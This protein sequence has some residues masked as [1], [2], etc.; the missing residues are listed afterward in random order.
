MSQNTDIEGLLSEYKIEE[1]ELEHVA[2]TD[3]PLASVASTLLAQLLSL[4]FQ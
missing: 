3:Y 2:A 1:S 4:L